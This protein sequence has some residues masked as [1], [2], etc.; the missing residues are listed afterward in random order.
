MFRAAFVTKFGEDGITGG[1][2]A[3]TML[4]MKIGYDD[5]ELSATMSMP[6]FI[7]AMVE[8]FERCPGMRCPRTP[9]P[10]THEDKKYEEPLDLG[11]KRLFQ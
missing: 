1:N 11:R 4:G 3:D 6:G 9:L 10:T 7:D 2:V 5:F 8:R